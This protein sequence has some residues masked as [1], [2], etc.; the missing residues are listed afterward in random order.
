MYIFCPVCEVICNL[1]Y[2]LI[3]RGFGAGKG[4]ILSSDRK[5]RFPEKK[6]FFLVP[7]LSLFVCFF[8]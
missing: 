1:A 8:L 6:I 5:L 2:L 7:F 4:G 3:L